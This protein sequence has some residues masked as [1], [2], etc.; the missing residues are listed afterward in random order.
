MK[1]WRSCSWVWTLDPLCECAV[2]AVV[3]DSLWR[4]PGSPVRGI[5]Q[6]R[7]LEWVPSRGGLPHPGTKLLALKSPALA[8][9]FLTTSTTY[10]IIFMA[11]GTERELRAFGKIRAETGKPSP[12]FR[13]FLLV[14]KRQ[15]QN[16][17]VP[18][19]VQYSCSEPVYWATSK[20]PRWSLCAGPASCYQNKEQFH[21]P[22]FPAGL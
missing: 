11:A 21:S 22:F 9:R 8:G 19:R 20:L 4:P 2:T 13:P 3:S 17:G 12:L 10:T 18:P 7:I 14:L 1:H 15:S 6:A 5:L 16:P